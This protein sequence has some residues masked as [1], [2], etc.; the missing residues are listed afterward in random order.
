MADSV[1]FTHVVDSLLAEGLRVRFRAAGRSMRPAVRDGECLVV[2]PVMAREVVRG[3]VV[4][5]ETSRG[6]VAHRVVA[7]ERD[8]TDVVRFL[9][10]GDAS[11]EPDRPLPATALR[12]RVVGVERAGRLCGLALPGGE[13]GRAWR[14]VMLRARPLFAAARAWLAPRPAPVAS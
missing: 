14:A 2:A 11:L 12:A 9:L 1:P 5:C 13:P 8:A 3:D 10:R 7:V 4:L 6:P